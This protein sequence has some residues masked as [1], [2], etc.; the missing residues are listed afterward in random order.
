[1]LVAIFIVHANDPFAKGW[2][3][4]FMYLLPY[5]TLILTGGSCFSVDRLI[6]TQYLMKKCEKKD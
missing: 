1:M 6:C 3:L 5:I 2:E 4:A